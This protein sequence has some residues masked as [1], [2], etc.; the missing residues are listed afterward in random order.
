MRQEAKNPNGCSIHKRLGA[1]I[2]TKGLQAVSYL[3]EFTVSP[4]R[5]LRAE[6]GSTGSHLVSATSNR[7]TERLISFAT[8]AVGLKSAVSSAHRPHPLLPVATESLR[9]GN[10][11]RD[12]RSRGSGDD[13]G[14]SS[15]GHPGHDATTRPCHSSLKTS[16]TSPNFFSTT[17][18]ENSPTF[19]SPAR[20]NATAPALAGSR[21]IPSARLIAAATFGS[22]VLHLARHRPRSE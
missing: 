14:K 21:N 20:L 9:C 4:K 10:T 8:S 5:R 17:A 15:R 3:T 1:G 18:P 13:N 19:G 12:R 7:G 16:G 22:P 2:L 11:W 6:R